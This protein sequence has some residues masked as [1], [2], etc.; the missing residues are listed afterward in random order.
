MSSSPQNHVLPLG[1]SP[2]RMV[3][4]LAL[5][6]I[7]NI[8]SLLRAAEPADLVP[9]GAQVKKL[10]GDFKF[11]E[12]PTWSPNGFLLFSDIPND[13]V[14][15]WSPDGTVREFL[16]PSGQSNGLAFDADG[17]L[18]LCR[19]GS[20]N[21]SRIDDLSSKS[22][23]VIADGYL[24]QPLNSPNDLV[25][26]Q[27]GGVYFTDPRYG[28]ADNVA[29]RVMGV[30]YLSSAGELTRIIEDLERPNGIG[31]SPDGS[32]LY[33]AEPN[34]RE[35][36]R[37]PVVS[38]GSVLAGT[39][40]YVGDE[41]EDGSGPDGFAVDSQG[42]LYCTYAGIVM[43][44]AHGQLLGRLAVPE[45]PANCKF[46]GAELKTLFITARTSL[47]S[48]ELSIPGIPAPRTAVAAGEK[49]KTSQSRRLQP[50]LQTVA[51]V[52]E[53]D[54]AEEKSKKVKAG[55]LSLEI[56][57]GW[58]FKESEREFRAA[59]IS[60]PA[61]KEDKDKGEIIVYYFGKQGA[62]TVNAN[63][64][65]WINQFSAEGRKVKVFKGKS[66]QGDYTLVD[67]TGTYNKPMGP[68]IL[69]QSK[70]MPNWRVLVAV[71]ETDNG[72]YFLKFDGPQKTVAAQEKAFRKTYGYEADSEKEDKEEE[73]KKN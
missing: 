71:I 19:G 17:R 43:L 38:P 8:P 56:P 2:A 33:V 52:E 28:N 7:G 41:K 70:P 9:S 23:R 64:E 54:A 22:L 21:I 48:I 24:E 16:K 67:L 42:H 65:R 5:A 6:L 37:Y 18:F 60:V 40:I 29:Q 10:A 66:T 31:L 55:D 14:M 3:C 4:L 72:P 51:F 58:E 50:R 73:A 47:Y 27:H 68:P 62:G 53:K 12:G 15:Q 63:V 49:T 25:L 30:Y 57:A 59:E 61:A 39:R 46:G 69:R 11:T 26:D 20:R 45:R 36:Y 44:D 13:R 32:W 35:L 1:Y 34:R